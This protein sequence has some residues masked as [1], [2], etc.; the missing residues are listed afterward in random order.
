MSLVHH[1]IPADLF[2]LGTTQGADSIRVRVHLPSGTFTSDASATRISFYGEG[3]I[4]L[5]PEQFQG[6]FKELNQKN[7]IKD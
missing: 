6:V 1:I 2:Q 4:S 3:M 5:S 7:Y